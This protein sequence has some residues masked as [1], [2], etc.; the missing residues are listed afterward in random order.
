V[1]KTGAGAGRAQPCEVTGGCFFTGVGPGGVRTTGVD[2]PLV[3]PD[4][5]AAAND[6]GSGVAD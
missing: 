3:A 5:I 2:V 6:A 1:L 4:A